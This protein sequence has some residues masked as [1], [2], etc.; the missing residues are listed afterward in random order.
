MFMFC[1]DYI[2]S[3][4]MKQ[5]MQLEGELYWA[6]KNSSAYKVPIPGSLHAPFY[7]LTLCHTIFVTGHIFQPAQV[8]QQLLLTPPC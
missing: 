8:E 1:K 6:Y 2:E 4:D 5:C 3:L 7:A